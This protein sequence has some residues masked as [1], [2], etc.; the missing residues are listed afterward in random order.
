VRVESA[1]FYLSLSSD[2]ISQLLSRQKFKRISTRS[3]RPFRCISNYLHA[4]RNCI[5][6][7][8]PLFLSVS[9]RNAQRDSKTRD[10]W[11]K[12]KNCV[13]FEQLC[14]CNLEIQDEDIGL[15]EE[16]FP[17]EP[18]ALITEREWAI[19]G[20]LYCRGVQNKD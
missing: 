20:N 18:G 10:E 9:R 4:A 5:L 1:R 14:I 2:V 19:E 8:K 11:T 17:A 13:H 15:Q 3:L 7:A 6:S 16:L 12:R